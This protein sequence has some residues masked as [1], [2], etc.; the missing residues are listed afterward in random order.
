MYG[1]YFSYTLA[2]VLS[3]SFVTHDL[4]SVCTL[5]DLYYATPVTMTLQP[6]HLLTCTHAA[7]LS[8]THTHTC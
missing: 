4:L 2:N 8:H 5:Q 1:Q 6:L 3:P 7:S